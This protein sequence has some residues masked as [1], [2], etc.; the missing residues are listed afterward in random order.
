MNRVTEFP[1]D[2]LCDYMIT[3]D[4]AYRQRFGK[5]AWAGYED[6]IADFGTWDTPVHDALYPGWHDEG[7]L[8]VCMMNLWEKYRYGR[9]KSR[10]EE[11]EWRRLCE[12]LFPAYLRLP[13]IAQENVADGMTP[14]NVCMF[15]DT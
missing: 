5:S 13:S 10:I 6:E 2:E 3:F 11:A 15:R 9:G 1:R 7:Y 14:P 4:K 12:G 8:E